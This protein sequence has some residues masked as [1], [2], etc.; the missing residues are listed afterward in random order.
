MG[1]IRGGT[2]ATPFGL[3]INETNKDLGYLPMRQTRL[4]SSFQRDTTITHLL[5]APKDK[6]SKLQK[7]EI[8]YQYKCLQI[9]CTE[10]YTGESGRIFGDRYKEHLK[11]PSPIHLYTTT[12][13]HPVSP[14]CFSILDMESQGMAWSGTSRRL[15]TLGSMTPLS[16]EIMENS[17]FHMYGIKYR[18]ITHLCVWFCSLW[19]NWLQKTNVV[20]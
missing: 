8:I 1:T 5:L 7:S 9:N 20:R 19:V 17:N 16:I 3:F 15:C 12:T 6:D 4:S 2:E 11:V 14:H 13:G 10:E 18:R